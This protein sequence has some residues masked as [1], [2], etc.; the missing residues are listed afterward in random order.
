MP[1]VLALLGVEPPPGIDGDSQAARMQPGASEDLERVVFAEVRPRQEPRHRL[2]AARTATAKW[3]LTESTP[4]ALASYDLQRDP[5]E[6]QPLDAPAARERGQALLARYG[7]S[8]G[9]ASPAPAA[10]PVD[11]A[12]T[13]KLRALGY[14]Q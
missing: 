6:R 11:D 2:V 3:I 8:R 1:T 13:A 9:D 7:S 4:S 5:A 12:T 10:V 14:L